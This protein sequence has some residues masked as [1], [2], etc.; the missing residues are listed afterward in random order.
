MTDTKNNEVVESKTEVKTD[1]E[2]VKDLN[3]YQKLAILQDK[4]KVNKDNRNEFADFQYRTIQNILAEL[5]PLLKELGLMIRFGSGK[6]DGEKYILDI[7]VTDINNP[8]NQIEENGEIY[9]DRTKAKMDLSQ[10]VLSA[11]TF[12][13]KSLLEDLLLISEDVDPDSHD[14][15]KMG[16][17]TTGNNNS[18]NNTKPKNANTEPARTAEE[19]DILSNIKNILYIVANKDQNKM[20]DLLSEQT[21]FTGKDNKVVPGLRDFDKLT[22]KRLTVTY[23]K[24]Q[25]AYPEAYK[26]FKAKLE[27]KQK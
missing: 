15:S 23:G 7:I 3:I 4:V 2:F 21:A 10:K 20:I 13:K 14:N 26:A 17:G 18:T 25:K 24:I 9:I 27:S 22:G 19:A 11:K 8:T 1:T 12:L 16:P 5:K 6:L